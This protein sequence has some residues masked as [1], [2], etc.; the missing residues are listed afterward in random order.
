MYYGTFYTDEL[1]SIYATTHRF[2]SGQKLNGTV[3]MH[4]WKVSEGWADRTTVQMSN[5]GGQTGLYFKGIAKGSL[6][7]DVYVLII[8]ANI[9]L[10]Y[11]WQKYIFRVEERPIWLLGMF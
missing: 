3:Y 11:G 9:D 8:E 7:P 1:I 10:V 2:E 5:V 6:D 4:Y